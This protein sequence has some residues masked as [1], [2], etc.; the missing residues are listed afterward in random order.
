MVRV[1]DLAASLEVTSVTIRTDLE[2]LERRGLAVRMHGGAVLPEHDELPRYINNTVHE[3]FEKKD[4]IARCALQLVYPDATVIIDA[5][6]TAA[7]FSRRLHGYAVTV[8]TNSVP[9]IAELVTDEHINL[10]ASGGAI[11]K[12][13]KAMVGEIARWAYESI[14]ADVVFLG[15]SGY[16]LDQGVTTP[17]LLEADT[18]RAMIDAAQTVCLLADS[19]KH[20]QVKFAKICDWDRIDYFMTDSAPT[21]LI[22]GLEARGVTVV[23][24]EYNGI[25]ARS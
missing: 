6:S 25:H 14:R 24:P 7:I 11:R 8:V 9:V 4:A 2:H 22:Q 21:D 1:N 17:N 19:T 20:E 18:K 3:N 5:G 12:P 16:S 15:A 23:T 10:I 13:V